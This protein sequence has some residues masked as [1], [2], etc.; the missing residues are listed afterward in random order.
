MNI[1]SL[2]SRIRRQ[3]TIR[4]AVS[5]ALCDSAIMGNGRHIILGIGAIVV[6][7]LLLFPSWSAHHPVDHNLIQPLG[8]AWIF[9]PPP[10]PAGFDLNV[11][12]DDLNYYLAA[13]V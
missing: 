9:S 2:E 4:T 5:T 3:R 10:A 11:E 8:F 7:L 6:V 1:R 13:I 12:R